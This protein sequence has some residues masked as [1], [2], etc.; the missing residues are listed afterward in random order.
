MAL[1]GPALYSAV[2]TY[3]GKTSRDSADSLHRVTNNRDF[4]TQEKHFQYK[5]FSFAIDNSV[6][7]ENL[8]SPRL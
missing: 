2:T 1:G 4:S 5:A 7:E 3:P 6:Q 8:Q